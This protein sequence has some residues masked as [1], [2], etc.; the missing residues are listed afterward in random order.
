MIFFAPDCSLKS[1]QDVTI[2]NKS[3]NWR[4]SSGNNNFGG[5]YWARVGVAG[6]DGEIRQ[7]YTPLSPET[8]S[9]S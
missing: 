6:D 5:G 7:P 1:F 8:G 4:S 2:L 9:E 3:F